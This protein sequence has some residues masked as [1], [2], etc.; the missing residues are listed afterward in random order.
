[1]AGMDALLAWVPESARSAVRTRYLRVNDLNLHFLEALPTATL[2]EESKQRLVILL[3]GFPELGYS[4]RKVLYPLSEAG[5]HVIA[6]DQRGYGRTTVVDESGGPA[7]PV[8]GKIRFEDDL[9]PFRMMNLVKDVVSLVYALG[10][11]SAAAVVGHD[12]GSLVAGYCS[13][14][15]PDVFR[16]VVMMSAPFPGAPL[17][18]CSRSSNVSGGPSLGDMAAVLNQQLAALDPPR[19]HYTLYFSSPEANEEL[20]N[21]P[22]GL[23]SFLQG[24]FR[25][26]SADWEGNQPHPLLSPSADNLA[27]MPRYYIMLLNETMPQAIRGCLQQRVGDE[28]HDDRDTPLAWLPDEDCAVYIAEYERTGFQGGLNWYRC[29]TDAKWSLDLQI[30]SGK[31]ISVPAMFLSGKQDWGTYQSPGTADRM[32]TRIC[33][34]MEEENFVLI[35]GAGHWVQQ[36]QSSEVVK[37]LLRFFS[38]VRPTSTYRNALLIEPEDIHRTRSKVVSICDDSL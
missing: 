30:F 13:L 28:G 1:M 7:A 6:P 34:R 31:R 2:A 3:H 8:N 4:W 35:A 9:A 26:K 29:M 5:Y 22:G 38:K 21:P 23:S 33:D 32:R 19:K 24:Y 14:I 12:F 16:S 10:Y 27:T 37:H 25:A 17:L 15:R 20:T 36:E 18:P 11:E